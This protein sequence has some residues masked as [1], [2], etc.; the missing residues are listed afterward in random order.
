MNPGT[1]VI[2]LASNV[3][4]PL[5]ISAFI[6]AVLPHGEEPAGLDRERLRLR[7]AGIDRVDLGVEDDQIGVLPFVGRAAPGHG[8]TGESRRCRLRSGL[9]ILYGCVGDSSSFVRSDAQVGETVH[10]VE[11]R[12]GFEEDLGLVGCRAATGIENDPGVGQLDVAGVFR[13]DHFAAK[14]PDVKSFDFS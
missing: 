11:I 7:R 10:S 6:S 2:C 12:T 3:W 14:N 4:V 5:P 1:M 9:G 8:A 13:L